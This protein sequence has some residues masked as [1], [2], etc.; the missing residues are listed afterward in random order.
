MH[1]FHL[2][3]S[4]HVRHGVEFSLFGMGL[5]RTSRINRGI[6]KAGH[7]HSFQ[8]VVASRTL[9]L[10]QF[11]HMLN[12]LGQESATTGEQSAISQ[13]HEIGNNNN[14]NRIQRRYLRF[15]YNLLTA[16]QTISNTHNQVARVQSCANHVQ[17]IER[18][19]RATCC[20]TCHLVRRDNSAIKFDRVDIAFICAY[21]VG[22]IIKPMKEGR[23]PEYPEK[24]PGD[25]LQK[26]PHST[27]RRFKPQARLKP[28]Q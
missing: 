3:S 13:K 12:Q 5:H 23:K 8:D 21:F 19:S 22:W 26:T 11:N 1:V 10:T 18:L 20:V 24:T 17:H 16:P 4:W 14:N 15:F 27:A 2:K 7:V 9:M 6:Y 28:T 25:E